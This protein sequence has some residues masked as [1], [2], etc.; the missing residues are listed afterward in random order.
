MA[1]LPSSR[2]A[3]PRRVRTQCPHR[4]DR[5]RRPLRS[6]DPWRLARWRR[7]TAWAAWMRRIRP[8]RTG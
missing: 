4:A 1:H 7:W 8:P 2:A 6:K 3:C 5:R